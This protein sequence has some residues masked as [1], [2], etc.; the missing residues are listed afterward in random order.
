MKNRKINILQATLCTSAAK[1]N[2]LDKWD[3]DFPSYTSELVDTKI[4]SAVGLSPLGCRK[5]QN[6][7]QNR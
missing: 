2:E 3:G 4:F 6:K 5:K 1:L 7:K